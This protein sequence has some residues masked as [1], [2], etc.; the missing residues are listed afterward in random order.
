MDM[1]TCEIHYPQLYFGAKPYDRIFLWSKDVIDAV[2]RLSLLPAS[3]GR[4]TLPAHSADVLCQALLC[5]FDM[6]LKR[7]E[8]PTLICRVAETSIDLG[9]KD[10]TGKAQGKR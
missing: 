2:G 6:V 1:I 7:V 9:Q 8:S 3:Y 5:E 4:G 10:L